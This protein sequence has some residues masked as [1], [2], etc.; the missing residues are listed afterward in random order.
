MVG[1]TIARAL[2]FAVGFLSLTGAIGMPMALWL[3]TRKWSAYSI[4]AAPLLGWGILTAWCFFFLSYITF[5]PALIL[6]FVGL[7]GL[8][9][10]WRLGVSTLRDE[11]TLLMTRHGLRAVGLILLVYP[12]YLAPYFFQQTLSTVI[13]NQDEEYFVEIADMFWASPQGSRLATTGYHLETGWGFHVAI[14]IARLLPFVHAFE[15]VM[16]VGYATLLLMG[17]GIFVLARECLRMPMP[18]ALG[19]AIV[20]PL[21]SLVLWVPGYAF[22]PNAVAAAVVPWYAITLLHG[23]SRPSRANGIVLSL[24]TGMLLMAYTKVTAIQIACIGVGIA[25]VGVWSVRTDNRALM[26][27]IRDVIGWHVLGAGI[28]FGSL[29]D[30]L[31]WLFS[32]GILQAGKL[33]S[34]AS[35]TTGAGWG[36]STFPSLGTWL[37]TEPWDFLRTRLGLGDAM[38]LESISIVGTVAAVLFAILGLAS[39]RLREWRPGSASLLIGHVVFYAYARIFKAFPY[40]VFKLQSLS[41]I[42][43]IILVVA[44]MRDVALGVRSG[45]WWLVSTT[46]MSVRSRSLLRYAGLAGAAAYLL[47]FG[48]ASATVIG[49]YSIP[50]GVTITSANIDELARVVGR[51]PA[52]SIV[53]ISNQIHGVVGAPAFSPTTHPIGF[54]TLSAANRAM[55]DRIRAYLVHSLRLRDVDPVGIFGREVN[56]TV[57]VPTRAQSGYLI[58]GETEDLRVRGLSNERIVESGDLIRLVDRPIGTVQD[59]QRLAGEV[60]VKWSIQCASDTL[61]GPC[62]MQSS[63]IGLFASD[64]TA[65]QL[66]FEC[67][68]VPTRARVMLRRGFTWYRSG[69]HATPCAIAARLDEPSSGA[70]VWV[71]TSS[72][73]QPARET[74]LLRPERTIGAVHADLSDDGALNITVTIASAMAESVPQELRVALVGTPIGPGQLTAT[75]ADPSRPYQEWRWTILPGHR[76]DQYINTNHIA[77]PVQAPWPDHDGDFWVR[78]AFMEGISIWHEVPLVVGTITHG[79]ITDVQVLAPVFDVP[80]LRPHDSSEA[81]VNPS[82]RVVRGSGTRVYLVETGALRW[83]PD[84]EVFTRHGLRWEDVVTIPDEDLN[85][86]P[87]GLPLD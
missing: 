81:T 73:G 61:P 86:I 18:W 84:L 48:A 46:E 29:A 66:T 11:A 63:V 85:S 74:G 16:L 70:T 20:A 12:I 44:G 8:L 41:G 79:R 32:G 55:G 42:L 25:A 52:K 71:A 39:P 49:F 38:W 65:I 83:V 27:R 22:G 10:T 78:L 58:A 36:L 47:A 28:A 68:A 59:T 40:A 24:M 75:D 69:P 7:A 80:F 1:F 31:I 87:L 30:S 4:L 17:A 72:V 62:P 14:A 13:P 56:S 15:A 2:V 34:D 67:D 54:A 64:S 57:K 35:E 21:H 3:Q 5:G 23:L 26:R 77:M 76:I 45:K 33:L 9:V 53:E 37:G 51:I 19:M 50:F 82:W 43:L 6:L 60:S